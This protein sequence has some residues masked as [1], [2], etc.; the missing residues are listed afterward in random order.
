MVHKSRKRPK[1][2]FV[3]V[4]LPYLANVQ[5]LIESVTLTSICVH[6]SVIKYAVYRQWSWTFTRACTTH[7]PRTEYFLLGFGAK[8]CNSIVTKQYKMDEVSFRA[9]SKNVF[10]LHCMAGPRENNVRCRKKNLRVKA[11]GCISS[12]ERAHWTEWKCS[13][14]GTVAQQELG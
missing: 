10:P 14:S 11:F 12:S 9:C 3:V 8:N 4:Y 2:T 7:P 1:Y 6:S 5:T 13:K